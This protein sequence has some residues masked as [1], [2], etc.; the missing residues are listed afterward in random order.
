MADP[1]HRLG[2][3][4]EAAV[5]RWLAGEGWVVLAERWRVAGGELDLV[6]RDP[7]GVLV[8]V[9]VRARRTSRAG[10]AAESVGRSR[11][12]RLR[13]AL[14]SFAAQADVRAPLRV[15]LVTVVPAR[16]L[17]PAAER[18]W[19]VSRVPAIDAW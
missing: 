18:R 1:R 19:R 6:M 15:D 9:E 7:D 2:L 14:M 12:L 17:G 16:G 4:A 8:G 13:H 3:E 5:G 10:S 11:V